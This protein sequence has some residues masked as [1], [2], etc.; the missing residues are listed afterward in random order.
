M[1]NTTHILQKSLDKFIDDWLMKWSSSHV[2]VKVCVK[3]YVQPMDVTVIV[4]VGSEA[5][6]LCNLQF[7]ISS[8]FHLWS[9][10]R[11]MNGVLYSYYKCC[12]ENK[13]AQIKHS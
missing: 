11:C 3:N 4:Y 12:H 2:D 6:T 1:D 8:V 7:A 13:I 9:F 5:N 10:K